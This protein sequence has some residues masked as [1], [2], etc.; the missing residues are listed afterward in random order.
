MFVHALEM[1][2]MIIR[3][4]IRYVNVIFRRFTSQ[5]IPNLVVVHPVPTKALPT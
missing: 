4:L 3:F 2:I 1:L 5:S